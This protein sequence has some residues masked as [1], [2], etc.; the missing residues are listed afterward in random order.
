M[1]CGFQERDGV[2]GENY[3]RVKRRKIGKAPDSW[4]H[5]K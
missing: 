2:V 4:S 1:S 3:C 5:L